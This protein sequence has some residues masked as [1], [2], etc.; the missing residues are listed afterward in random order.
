MT[1]KIARYILEKIT[2]SWLLF[3]PTFRTP[4]PR[5]LRIGA[6][7]S[8]KHSFFFETNCK[9]NFHHHETNQCLVVIVPVFLAYNHILGFKW[10]EFSF[11]V[12]LR[13]GKQKKPFGTS[14]N[15]L[16]DHSESM[17]VQL[18][19]ALPTPF[20]WPCAVFHRCLLKICLFSPSFSFPQVYLCLRNKHT[21]PVCTITYPHNILHRLFYVKICLGKCCIKQ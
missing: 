19:H 7:I 5:P 21:R 10:F 8:C 3:M 13:Q 2:L 6:K 11:H 17:Y 1:K 14:E 4:F 18:C 12:K 16:S 15:R 9:S 20:V